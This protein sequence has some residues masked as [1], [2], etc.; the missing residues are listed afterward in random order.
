MSRCAHGSLPTVEC[1]F[2]QHVS[3]CAPFFCNGLW[4]HQYELCLRLLQ[5]YHLPLQ[6]VKSESNDILT[7]CIATLP[8]NLDISCIPKKYRG[9]RYQINHPGASPF[10]SPALS[11]GHDD[12][13]SGQSAHDN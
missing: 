13:L 5:P 11:A 10:V 9:E 7:L 2:I 12:Q 1:G 6:F 3:H 8:I 4:L